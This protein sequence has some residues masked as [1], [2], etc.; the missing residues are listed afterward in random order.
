MSLTRSPEP[1]RPPEVPI[2][3]SASALTSL[4]ECPARWFLEREAG[5]EQI[6]T[7]AQ[8]SATWFT[9]WPIGSVG[10]RSTSQI[11]T[12][13][14]DKLMA[15]VDRV[16]GQLPF[17]TPWSASRERDEVIAALRRFLAW[18]TRPDARE[19]LATEKSF[20]VG[21][22]LPD[23]NDVTLHGYADRLELDAEGRVVVIDLKTGKYPPPDGELAKN[24]QLGLYQL[25]V[26]HGGVDALLPEGTERRVRRCRV[27]A[28]AQGALRKAQGATPGG[29]GGRRAAARVRSSCN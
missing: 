8:V 7:Q 26:E 1:I 22:R 28:V 24:P 6:A 13:A 14:L 9:P 2:S 15:H 3:L 17:R 19:L 20:R 4:D 10:A 16:W 25:A 12:V 29:P 27:V 21:L 23:G 11:R 18:H 5:G